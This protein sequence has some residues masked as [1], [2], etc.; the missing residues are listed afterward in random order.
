MILKKIFDF[1]QRFI[2]DEDSRYTKFSYQIPELNTYI[3]VKH[4]NNVYNDYYAPISGYL[5]YS[6]KNELYLVGTSGIAK[7]KLYLINF[8]KDSWYYQF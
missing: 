8:S 6:D 7:D 2:P 1:L 5:K 3:I 4:W